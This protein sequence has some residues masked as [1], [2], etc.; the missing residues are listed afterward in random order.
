M[1]KDEIVNHGYLFS[2]HKIG[3]VPLIV[4]SPGVEPSPCLAMGLPRDDQIADNPSVT[5]RTR[6]LLHIP[7]YDSTAPPTKHLHFLLILPSVHAGKVVVPYELV[8]VLPDRGV[9]LPDA[10]EEIGRGEIIVL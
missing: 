10:V 5:E 9:R 8:V 1:R 7:L 2:L 6:V 3:N 4:N